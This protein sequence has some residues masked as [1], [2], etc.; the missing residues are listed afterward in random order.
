MSVVSFE[1]SEQSYSEHAGRNMDTHNTYS[2]V[3]CHI[4]AEEVDAPSVKKRRT[5]TDTVTQK[6]DELPRRYQHIRESIRKV[7]PE[8]Y[9]TVDKL[10]SCYHMSECQAESAVIAVGNKMFGQNWKAHDES[11][12]IDLDTLPESKS[13]RDAGKSIEVMALDEIV[14]EIMNSDEQVVVTY[15]DDGSKKQGTGSGYYCQWNIPCPTDHEHC[16]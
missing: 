6:D 11:E 13:I 10:K 9:E 4:S 8:F 15:S 2:D 16:F 5:A 7:R 1:D 3:E 14:K 12:I